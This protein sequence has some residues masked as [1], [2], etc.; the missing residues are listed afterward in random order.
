MNEQEDTY[1]LKFIRSGVKAHEFR[2]W[3]G[4]VVLKLVF[5][6]S[7]QWHSSEVITECILHIRTV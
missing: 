2:V 1:G 7:N 3:G 5:F 6:M 4:T